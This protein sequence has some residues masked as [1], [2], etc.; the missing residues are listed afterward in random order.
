MFAVEACI[1]VGNEGICH[2]ASWTGG[3]NSVLIA[4]RFRSYSQRSQ[5]DLLLPLW[6]HDQ[7]SQFVIARPCSLIPL[8]FG[9]DFCQWVINVRCIHIRQ[10]VMSNFRYQKPACTHYRIQRCIRT[11]KEWHFYKLCDRV[12]NKV[13]FRHFFQLMIL[14]YLNFLQLIWLFNVLNSF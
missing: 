12:V 11:G 14:L 10:L 2:G 3:K 9:G 7:L 13:N 5:L 4:E 8:Q 1:F 6:N